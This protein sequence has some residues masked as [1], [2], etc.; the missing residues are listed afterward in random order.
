[1]P[2]LSLASIK[3]IA[4]AI[5]IAAAASFYGL[6]R[7][8]VSAYAEFKATVKAQGDIAIA[9]KKSI[10]ATHNAVV[11]EIKNAIPAKIEAARTDAVRNYLA[12]LPKRPSISTVPVPAVDTAVPNEP[13]K[14]SVSCP[15]DDGFIEDASED[16]AMILLW[17]EW[18]RKIGFKVE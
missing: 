9:E 15:A 8:E 14:E 1:M 10:E 3:Y 18:A 6:W 2:T 7:H 13:A 12:R 11:Q 16:V 4:L 17:Q 5:L